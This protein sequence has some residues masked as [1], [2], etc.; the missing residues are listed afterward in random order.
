MKNFEENPESRGREEFKELVADFWTR[1]L[2]AG[3]KRHDQ[4]VEEIRIIRAN[5]GSV[6]DYELWHMLIGSTPVESLPF[7]TPEGKIAEIFFHLR[8]KYLESE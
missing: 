7:D 8:K 1:L 6:S 3:D 2:D 4:A 5:D